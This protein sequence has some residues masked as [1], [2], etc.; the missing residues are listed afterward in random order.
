MGRK[1]GKSYQKRVTDINRIYDR[2]AKK[3]IPNREIWRR[4]I[5]PVY[6]ICERTF[7][8]L[9]NAPTKPGFSHTSHELPTLFDMFKD[10]DEHWI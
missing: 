4:Y 6:G 3:G 8:N 5:Y 1:P 10:D 9:L 7:Y 2:Y